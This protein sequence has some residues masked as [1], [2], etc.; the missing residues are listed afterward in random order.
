MKRYWM[1]E[2]GGFDDFGD[3][4]EDEMIDGATVHGPWACMTPRSWRRHGRGI[5]GQ[6]LGQRYERQADGRWLKV[7]G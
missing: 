7:E 3:P 5:L 1:G 4:Y 6:G 2:L